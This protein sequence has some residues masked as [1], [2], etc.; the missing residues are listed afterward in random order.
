MKQEPFIRVAVA[1]DQDIYRRGLVSLITSL[2]PTRLVGEARD[3]TEAVQLC[4]ML[5]PDILLLDIKNLPEGGRELVHAIHQRWP[6]IKV[7]FLLNS[8]EENQD[9]DDPADGEM[10]YFSKDIS[11]DEFSKAIQDIHRNLR[12]A[13]Q[14][15]RSSPSTT[16]QP[17]P[18]PTAVSVSSRPKESS[19]E[20]RIRELKMAGRIQADI[21]PESVPAIPGWDIS[22]RLL[23]ARETS[24]DFFD[25]IPLDD[26]H[27]GIVVGDVTDKSIGAALFMAL[28][29][30]LI[31]T[32]AVRYPTL[33]ALAMD[34]VNQRMLSDTRGNIF[35]TAFYGVL[36]QKLARLRF[37]NAGHPPALLV[38]SRGAKPIDQLKPTGAALGM[39]EKTHWRQKV[40]KF[41]PGDILFLYTDGITE[42]QN[43]SGDFYGI[44]RLM[45][46]LRAAAGQPAKAILDR[47]LL[48]VRSFVGKAPQHDDIAAVTICRK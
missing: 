18:S 38:C 36:E 3:E 23:S 1:S 33:P 46:V 12:P 14:P 20:V 16:T 44:Q 28:T 5:E 48:D 26:Q 34:V 41:Q 25:F 35:V 47:V 37:V 13:P 40:V 11:E 30:T 17:E 7:V 39:L 8:S 2:S 9:S 42:A 4:E 43:P 6:E 45:R 32:Y 27:W 19:D 15:A 22:A 24:G 29:S 10:I 21:L 31:R